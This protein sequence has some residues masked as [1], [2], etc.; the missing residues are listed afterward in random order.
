VRSASGNFCAICERQECEQSRKG[1]F[2]LHVTFDNGKKM[3]VQGDE[4]QI[5]ALN[6]AVVLGSKRD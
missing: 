2:H 1:E 3:Q 5:A 4:R 6:D